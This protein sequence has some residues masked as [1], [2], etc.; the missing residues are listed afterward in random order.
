MN[1]CECDELMVIAAFRYCL[2][3]RSYIT[4]ECVDCLIRIWHNLSDNTRL[5]IRQE[6]DRAAEKH[7]AGV[8][9]LLGDETDAKEWERLRSYYN[10]K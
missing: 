1:M 6:L 2:G 5:I 8:T 3:R 4:G 9:E 7:Y 10:R